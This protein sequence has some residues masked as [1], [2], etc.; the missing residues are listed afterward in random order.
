MMKTIKDG[1]ASMREGIVKKAQNGNKRRAAD[2]DVD[3]G[4]KL[5]KHK[6]IQ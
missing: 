2:C 6:I 4:I 1:P 5:R 3:S